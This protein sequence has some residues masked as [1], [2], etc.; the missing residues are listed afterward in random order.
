MLGVIYSADNF[1]KYGPKSS[2]PVAFDVKNCKNKSTI[3]KWR[4][5]FAGK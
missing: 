4:Q 2:N 1:R 5:V 3:Q